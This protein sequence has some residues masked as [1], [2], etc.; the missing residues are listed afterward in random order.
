MFL[1]TRQWKGMYNVTPHIGMQNADIFSTNEKMW[2][3]FYQFSYIYFS[4][5]I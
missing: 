3:T 2:Y 4:K 1:K 5:E